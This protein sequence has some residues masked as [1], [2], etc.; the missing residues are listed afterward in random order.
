MS[1]SGR[2]SG[3]PPHLWALLCQPLWQPQGVHWLP[4]PLRRTE[5]GQGEPASPQTHIPRPACGAL[6]AWAASAPVWTPRARWEPRAR[7]RPLREPSFHLAPS[8]LLLPS[9]SPAFCFPFRASLTATP[10][11]PTAAFFLVPLRDPG[12]ICLRFHPSLAGLESGT[13]HLGGLS[14]PLNSLGHRFLICRVMGVAQGLPGCLGDEPGPDQAPFLPL[15]PSTAPFSASGDP[16]SPFR[17]KVW[18]TEVGFCSPWRPSW[19]STASRRW[20]TS[21][22]MT[23]FG[24]R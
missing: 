24:W 7:Q 10:P 4:R 12:L 3:L 11:P 23:S 1:P 20:R 14:C 6:P 16:T 18:P 5:H 15:L 17:G 13:D 2:P 21:L 19:W 9:Y 8:W 22:R